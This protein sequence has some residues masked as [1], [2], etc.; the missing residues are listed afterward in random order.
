MAV[1]IPVTVLSGVLGAGKTTLLNHALTA[2]DDREIAVVVN[3]M[4][5]VNVDA[6]LVE[7]TVKGVNGE[8]IVELSNGCICCSIQ[9]E[10]AEGV[11]TLA[12]AER[13]DHLLV[14]PSGISDPKQ[15]VKRFLRGRVAGY[16]DVSSVTTVVDARRFYD[17]FETDSGDSPTVDD[18][19]LAEL[20]IEGVEFCDTV[21]VNKMDL[22]MAAQQESLLDS[23]RVLQPEATYIP[24][25]FGAVDP[26]RIL[27]QSRFDP[28]TVDEAP[29]WK[30]LLGDDSE[31]LE[32][33][34]H[35]HR[36]LY[37]SFTYASHRPFHPGRLVETLTTLPR[38]I[39]RMKGRLHVTGR[40]GT[41]LDL[42]MA[43]GEIHVTA[44]GRW[45]ASLEPSRQQCYR[46]RRNLDWDDGWGDR[47]TE[48]VVIGRDLPVESITNAFDAA[49][50]TDP[51]LGADGFENPFASDEDERLLL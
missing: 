22:V 44:S 15:V 17:A 5:D 49:R 46:E 31:Q 16:Y 18:R 19:P 23:L 13:F 37:M 24:T 2:A 36:E 51:E 3:D 50:C 32:H 7:R 28:Q 39:L 11:I 43:G 8:D 6:E 38:G 35:L 27:D 45:I 42:S 47:K 34:S 26:E 29:R 25:Q 20:M 12:E 30:Q 10:L 1:A 41:A 21:V 14:E 9:G 33:G 40:P 48:L 4:G